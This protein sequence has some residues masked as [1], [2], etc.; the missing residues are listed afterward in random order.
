MAIIS[1]RLWKSKEAWLGNEISCGHQRKFDWSASPW[2]RHWQCSVIQS[3][4]DPIQQGLYI[5]YSL[6]LGNLPLIEMADEMGNRG[7]DEW[8]VHKWKGRSDDWHSWNIN[9]MIQGRCSL[10]HQGTYGAAD[11]DFGGYR[12]ILL[13]DT[14]QV[15]NGQNTII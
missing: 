10:T 13:E 6:N 7:E 3:T 5:G 15:K 14:L 1:P 4:E 8:W 12:W 2:K 11:L 9:S